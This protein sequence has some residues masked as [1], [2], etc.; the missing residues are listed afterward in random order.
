MVHLWNTN[1][2]LQHELQ[3]NRLWGYLFD[4]FWKCFLKGF[5]YLTYISIFCFFVICGKV[6]KLYLDGFCLI[7]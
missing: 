4:I 7:N 3:P 2:S 5:P 1:N 6:N